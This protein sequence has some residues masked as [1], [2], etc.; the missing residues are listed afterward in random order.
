MSR[1]N[2]E[3]ARANISKKRRTTMREKART[4][5]AAAQQPA[6]TENAPSTK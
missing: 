6:K 2:G 3:K 5:R 4:A 1:I